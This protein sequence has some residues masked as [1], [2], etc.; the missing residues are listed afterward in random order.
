M[1]KHQRPRIAKETLRKKNKAGSITLSD[2]E[3]HYKAIVFKTVWY[4]QKI[5]Q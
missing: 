5:D 2:S 4:W 1:W 3:L